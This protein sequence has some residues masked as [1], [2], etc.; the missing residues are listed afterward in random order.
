MFST[1]LEPVAELYT[2][3]CS[4]FNL[5]PRLFFQF[6][7]LEDAGLG[8]VW[9]VVLGRSRTIAFCPRVSNKHRTFT[10]ETIVTRVEPEVD[11]G[12]AAI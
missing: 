12:A 9:I 5:K 2:T 11:S 4:K 10:E 6:Q 1:Y 8:W 7:F 3:N